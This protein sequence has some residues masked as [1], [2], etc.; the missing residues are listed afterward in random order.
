MLLLPLVVVVA[1]IVVAITAG[2]RV[3]AIG[4]SRSSYIRNTF[5]VLAQREGWAVF[6]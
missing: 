1:I 6:S 5:R 4:F 3:R 2:A